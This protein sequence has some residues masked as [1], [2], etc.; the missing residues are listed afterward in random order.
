MKRVQRPFSE[1][2]ALCAAITDVVVPPENV[3]RRQTQRKVITYS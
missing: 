2:I 1:A 3:L